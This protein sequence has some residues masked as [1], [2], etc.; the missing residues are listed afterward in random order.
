M[1]QYAGT[2]ELREYLSPDGSLGT[3]QDGLLQQCLDRAESG[4]NN[5]TRR[6]FATV[7]ATKYYSRHVARIANNALY[8]MEDL[9]ALGTLVTGDG[10]NV[11]VGTAGSVWLEPVNAGP[12]YRIIRLYSSFVWTFNTDAQIS[13]TG[14]WGYS[15]TPP[16]DI[17]QATI[18]YA[19][20][21]YRQKD[22]GPSDV[23][24][25]PDGGE[26]SY[27]KGMPDDVR[28]ILS[29]YRSRSGGVV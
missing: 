27:P 10:R 15:D 8:L 19:A 3:E 23:S 2:T 7:Q 11:P 29:P 5:Y 12:P 16:D 14:A 24:G 28:W 4:I 25:F 18:R 13:I 22:T 17:V 1:S 6:S 21:L 20:Y 9:F 26:V